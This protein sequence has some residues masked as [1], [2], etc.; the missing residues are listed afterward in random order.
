MVKPI[1]LVCN[2]RIQNNQNSGLS[3]DCMNKENEKED[4]ENIVK[5]AEECFRSGLLLSRSGNIKKRLY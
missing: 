3:G 5:V 1:N 2:K 4:N